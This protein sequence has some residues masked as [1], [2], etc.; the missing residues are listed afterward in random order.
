M[1]DRKTSKDDACVRILDERTLY[2]GFARYREL[3]VEERRADGTTH[4]LSREYQTRGDVVAVLPFD[5]ERK[6]ALLARQLRVPLL[7]RGDGEA[8]L[9]EAPAGYVDDGEAPADAARRE[10]AE[11]V[12]IA[13]T[14]LE[15]VG[16]VYSSPGAMT[17][18]ISLFL[19]EYTLADRR[20]AGGGLAH[21]GE[22]IEVLECPL[23]RLVCDPGDATGQDAKTLL[24]LQALMLRRPDLFA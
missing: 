13:L 18:R 24:L 23:A 15:P 1:S 16:E 12:G 14:D 21:E 9:L 4:R 8:F 19:A 11:E 10:A 3:D 17:E 5:P 20:S 6:V 7:A 22:E 2:E